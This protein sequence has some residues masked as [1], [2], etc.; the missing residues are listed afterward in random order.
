[1]RAAR[2]AAA[3]AAAAALVLPAT[4]A[5]HGLSGRADLPLPRWL[6]AW[7]AVLVLV[8]SFVALASLWHEPKLEHPRERRVASLPAAVEVACGAVG[9]VVLTLLIYAG[10]W[11]SPVPTENIVP[12][13]V[14]VL[15]WVGL[16]PVSALL[17]NVFRLFNPWLAV[18]RAL[19][20]AVGRLR[21][22][23]V[24]KPLPYP[25]RLG[26]WPA[27][28]GLVAFGWIELVAADGDDPSL[29]ALLAL[30]YAAFQLVG[31]ALYGIETWAERGDAFGIYFGFFA[32]LAPLDFRPGE[33]IVRRPLAGLSDVVWLPGTVALVCAAIGITAF[34][35]ASEGGLWSDVARPLQRA[36]EGLGLSLS[37]AAQLASTLG[38][39]ASIGLVAAVYRAGVAGMR[40]VERGRSAGEL[41]G[42]FA[43]S[44]V[45]VALAYV[46]AHYF[47][48]AVFQGQATAY[49]VSDPLGSGTDLF[50]TAD[51]AVDYGAV[52]TSA[53]WYVQVGTLVAGPVAG[54]TVAHDRALAVFGQLG[55]AT[56]SQYWM[57]A[58]MVG[59]TSLGLW[60]LS[61]ANP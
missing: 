27:V 41:A 45:P 4:A 9:V 24:P 49:L 23:G 58:V 10:R 14:Y 1:M 30:L 50:G 12:T 5:A 2:V 61:Q 31:M 37:T 36:L 48:L 16:V 21:R 42:R 20:F 33:I 6:F 3:A 32:R 25:E 29:L 28:F 35:G 13:F 59:F 52:S 39:A 44:L 11:G 56:R 43:H 53:I 15:F 34:D 54:L 8:F 57:L 18:A 17:G 55:A 46:I 7:A 26:R 38:L 51:A 22:R 19:R 40:S 47:S 60:L